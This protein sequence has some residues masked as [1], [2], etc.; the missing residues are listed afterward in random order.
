MSGAPEG[1]AGL[2]ASAFDQSRNGMLLVDGRRLVVD[3]NAALLGLIGRNRE[4]VLGR[5]LYALL[6]HG[7][8]R[9]PAEWAAEVLRGE[10]V[11][12]DAEFTCGSGGTVAVQWAATPTVVSGRYMV[13]IVALSTSRWGRH[14]RRGVVEA[15][16]RPL[17]PRE[18]EIVTLVAHGHSGPEIA[19]DLHLAQDTV[20]TH[21]RNAMTKVGARSRAHLVAKAVG[22]GLLLVPGEEPEADAVGT[23]RRTTFS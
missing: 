2:F 19:D 18:R 20:R 21:V 4:A 11:T 14:F 13:L 22:Q 5:P 8:L 1:W 23:P 9:T 7:P 6:A 3:V 17:S 12:G 15:D 16:G 10:R